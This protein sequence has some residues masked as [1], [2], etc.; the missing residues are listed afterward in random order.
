MPKNISLILFL[1][2][3]SSCLG[4]EHDAHLPIFNVSGLWLHSA[5]KSWNRHMTG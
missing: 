2:S 3:A 4:Y 5:T 1:F